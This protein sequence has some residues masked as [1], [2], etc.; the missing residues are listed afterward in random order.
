M[1]AKNDI[2]I[3]GPASLSNSFIGD[4]IQ[5]CVVTNDIRRTLEGFTKLGVGP[6]RIYTFSPETVKDQTYLGKPAR[7]SMRLALATSGTMMWEVIQ[8]LEGPS[9][10]KDF[11][12]K[13]GEGIQQCL[14]EGARQDADGRRDARRTEL[15]HRHAVDHPRDR[16]GG[17][18]AE[19]DDT[20]GVSDRDDRTGRQQDAG[21]RRGA[22]QSG[23]EGL[24]CAATGIDSRVM[25]RRN[26]Q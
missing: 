25:R 18:P 11:L 24:Q 15:R 19:R 6:W 14:R 26:T 12:A 1:S 13:H 22:Q 2:Q 16:L 8:P 4:T 9:I 23:V 21:G 20:R 10:Y 17:E 3:T 5:V 7:Y